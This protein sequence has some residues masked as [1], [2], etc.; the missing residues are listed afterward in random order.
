MSMF[1]CQLDHV[2]IQHDNDSPM[3]LLGY[4]RQPY[5]KETLQNF[6]EIRRN[7]SESLYLRER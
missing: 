1:I 3:L 6:Q 2:D 4:Q 5:E 7:T